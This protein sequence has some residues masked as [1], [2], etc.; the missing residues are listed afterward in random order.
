ME[1]NAVDLATFGW[2]VLS[3]Q[4]ISPTVRDNRVFAP[5]SPLCILNP[6]STEGLCSYGLG[7]RRSYDG[8][9]RVVEHGGSWTGARSHILMYRD[10]GL[11]IA[12][13]SNRGAHEPYWLARAIGCVV[14]ATNVSGC[15]APP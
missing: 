14:L 3:G 1:V 6:A 7:W 8:A 13:L 12:I 5:V 11:V 4:I 2:K 15:P 10:E 9:R